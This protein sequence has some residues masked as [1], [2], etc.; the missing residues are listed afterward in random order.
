VAQARL[1]YRRAADAGSAEALQRLQMIAQQ[2]Q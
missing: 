1:W 2:S